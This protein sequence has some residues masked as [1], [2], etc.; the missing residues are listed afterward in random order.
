MHVVTIVVDIIH[1]VV[2][3][4]DYVDVVAGA[5]ATLRQPLIITLCSHEV[6]H[7]VSTCK[8]LSTCMTLLAMVTNDAMQLRVVLGLSGSGATL[9]ACLSARLRPF[10]IRHKNR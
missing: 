3:A 10:C 4:S 1:V 5:P 6:L 8:H 9:T 7:L 2:V